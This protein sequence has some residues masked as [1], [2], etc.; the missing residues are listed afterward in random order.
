MV[1]RS[2][3]TMAA[4]VLRTAN[5][6]I[7]NTTPHTPP[8]LAMACTPTMESCPDREFSYLPCGGSHK[9]RYKQTLSRMRNVAPLHFPP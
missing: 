2:L 1:V 4:V 6:S 3:Q 5:N 7:P 8:E 9:P